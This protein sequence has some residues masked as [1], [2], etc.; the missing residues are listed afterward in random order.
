MWVLSHE[1]RPQMRRALMRLFGEYVTPETQILYRAGGTDGW[2]SIG[3]VGN[4]A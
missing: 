2:I 1:V 3:Y 4:L